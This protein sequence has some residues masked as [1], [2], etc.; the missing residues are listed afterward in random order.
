VCIW[1]AIENPD[2]SD[3]LY[4]LWFQKS[5]EDLSK[6]LGGL[7]E[8]ILD[9]IYMAGEIE[10][11]ATLQWSQKWIGWPAATRNYAIEY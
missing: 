3:Q 9:T 5:K 10:M 4:R 6:I 11:D 2:G 1:A 7:R 8:G